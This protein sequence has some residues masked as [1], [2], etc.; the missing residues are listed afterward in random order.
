MPVNEIRRINQSTILG[1][2]LINESWEELY[3][4]AFLSEHE[5]AEFDTFRNDTRKRQWLAYRTLIREMLGENYLL[6]YD[7]DGKPHINEP[8][9]FVSVSHSKDY[10]AVIVSKDKAVG[11]DVEMI[12][13]RIEKVIGKFLSEEEIGAVGTAKRLEKLFVY[14]SGKEALYKLDGKG[15]ADFSHQILFGPFEYETPGRLTG[16]IIRH[17]D[18]KQYTVNYEEMSEYMLAYAIE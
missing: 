17:G 7:G 6:I 10:A 4:K 8:G 16:R 14:W 15:A 2:W 11:I 3:E 12:H 18:E 5:L 9:H 13:P 1:T